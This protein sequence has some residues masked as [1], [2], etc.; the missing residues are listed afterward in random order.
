MRTRK[1]RGRFVK[2]NVDRRWWYVIKFH[3][4]W[5]GRIYFGSLTGIVYPRIVRG[6][7]KGGVIVRIVFISIGA[8]SKAQNCKRD[9]LGIVKLQLVAKY[10]TKKG[11][12]A[13]GDFQKLPKKVT[14]EILNSVTAP[15][16]VKGGS[17]RI[18]RH[19][20]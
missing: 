12:G 18:F 5:R 14:N 20:L 9:P 11:R 10:E 17:F 1:Q 6:S 2:Y 13:F 4:S 15:K 16:N 7:V 19:A 8:I 3:R